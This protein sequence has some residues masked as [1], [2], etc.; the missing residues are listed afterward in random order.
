MSETEKQELLQISE[1]TLRKTLENIGSQTSIT[2]RISP[3]Y[4]T[5]E[6]LRVDRSFIRRLQIAAGKQKIQEVLS[7]T[8]T[9]TASTQEIIDGIKDALNKV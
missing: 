3:H 4:P 9:Y 7:G 8:I 1:N 6:E 5:I 2:S